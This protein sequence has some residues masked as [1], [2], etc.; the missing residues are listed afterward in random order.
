MRRA[1]SRK[2]A[3]NTLEDYVYDPQGHVISVHDAGANLLRAE[4]YTG[5]RTS[6]LEL[7]GLF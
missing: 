7:N 1:A 6:P 3:A 2:A 5:G 4:L